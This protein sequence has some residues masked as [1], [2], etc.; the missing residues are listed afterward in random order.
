M[1]DVLACIWVVVVVIVSGGCDDGVG[2]TCASCDDDEFCQVSPR[3]P[4]LQNGNPNVCGTPAS[5]RC[6]AA[7]DACDGVAS[8]S[9]VVCDVESPFPGCQGI[10]NCDDADGDVIV[11]V[12]TE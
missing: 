2:A 8:C 7:P 10:G 5:A 11:V 9:C 3:Q 6:L 1:R 12:P 4:F